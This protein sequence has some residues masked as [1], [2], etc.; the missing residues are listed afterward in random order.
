MKSIFVK[1]I[2][3]LTVLCLIACEKHSPSCFDGIMNQDEE[4]VD[5]GGSCQTCNNGFSCT[6]GI[7][8]GTETE[9]D[10]G[11]ECP[12]CSPAFDFCSDGIQNNG[13]EGIDCG[14]NCLLPCGLCTDI[15]ANYIGSPFY[16]P[17]SVSSEYLEDDF[18]YVLQVRCFSGDFPGNT[19]YARI[20]LEEPYTP[21]SIG[22]YTSRPFGDIEYGG[23]SS[24][25][26]IGISG[27][28]SPV[29]YLESNQ[30]V[31][32]VSSNPLEILVCDLEYYFGGG[33]GSSV[34]IEM[35]IIVDL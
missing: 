20:R 6:D 29:N 19:I 23:Y 33:F 24:G 15:Q 4:G 12:P 26:I 27:Q 1:Y 7:L 16:G 34:D 31:Y 11:G 32:I 21:P 3:L 18:G 10:C 8:N 5:C 17:M 25:Q 30:E 9:I 35:R 14:G 2:L 28:T 22:V 13:E